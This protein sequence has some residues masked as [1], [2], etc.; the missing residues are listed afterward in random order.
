MASRQWRQAMT[1]P[2]TRSRVIDLDHVTTC[3]FRSLAATDTVRA[4]VVKSFVATGR[5][6]LGTPT[7]NSPDDYMGGLRRHRLSD[8]WQRT[9]RLLVNS[10]SMLVTSLCRVSPAETEGSSRNRSFVNP[11]QWIYMSFTITWKLKCFHGW[12]LYWKLPFWRRCSI[13]ICL[14]FIT[15]WHT[16]LLYHYYFLSLFHLIELPLIF[17]TKLQS[18]CFMWLIECGCSYVN[19]L[20]IQKINLIIINFKVSNISRESDLG[21]FSFPCIC[22]FFRTRYILERIFSQP[23]TSKLSLT[24]IINHLN[25]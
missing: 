22:I 2:G 1:S 8:D 12:N 16:F 15:L 9:G 25:K 10:V 19:F 21:G 7:M 17:G 6:H 23:Y 5:G 13:F 14:L 24:A 4:C 3:D 20:S 11:T 18:P